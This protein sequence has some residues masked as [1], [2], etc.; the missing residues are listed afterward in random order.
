MVDDITFTP[1]DAEKESTVTR[2]MAN[3]QV[4]V[5]VGRSCHTQSAS[6]ISSAQIKDLHTP[7]VA[8]IDYKGRRFLA[9][10]PVPG[11]LDVRVMRESEL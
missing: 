5:S 1:I 10:T 6:Q 4:L 3:Y 8:V 11:L 7:L 2:Q 9:Q